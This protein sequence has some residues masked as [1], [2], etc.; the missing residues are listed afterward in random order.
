MGGEEGAKKNGDFL[1]KRDGRNGSARLYPLPMKKE[2]GIAKN[3]SP[4]EMIV[5]LSE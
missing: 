4:G 2:T 1:N 5:K 3:L